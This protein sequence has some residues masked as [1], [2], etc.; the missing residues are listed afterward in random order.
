M[1]SSTSYRI[2][3]WVEEEQKKL[4]GAQSISWSKSRFGATSLLHFSVPYLSGGSFLAQFR[5][6]NLGQELFNKSVM[7]KYKSVDEISILF[8]L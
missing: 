8:I 3:K 6:W 4:K 1:C 5:A 2:T 7:N